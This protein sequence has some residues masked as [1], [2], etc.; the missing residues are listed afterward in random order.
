MFLSTLD[1]VKGCEYEV[2]GC[3]GNTVYVPCSSYSIENAIDEELRSMEITPDAV[4]GIRIIGVGTH[5]NFSVTST[6]IRFTDGK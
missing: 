2:I 4:I 5:L 1:D 3:I 6:A